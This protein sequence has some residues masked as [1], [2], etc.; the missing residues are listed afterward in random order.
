MDADGS[1]KQHI[2]VVLTIYENFAR[3]LQILLYSCG[4][5]TRLRI[6]EKQSLSREG[7][8]WRKLHYL[9]A[10]TNYSREKIN[11]I[12][13]LFKKFQFTSQSA[14]SFPVSFI[15]DWRVK[16]KYCRERMNI[17]TYCKVYGDIKMC[18]CEVKSVIEDIDEQTYDIEVEGKSEFYCDGYLCHNSAFLILGH[19]EDDEFIHLKDY[20]RNPERRDYGWSSN[21]SIIAK[22]GMDYSRIAEIIVDRGEPGIFWMENARNY[23][24]MCELPDYKDKKVVGTN[25]CVSGDTLIAVADGRI[26]VS[27]KQLAEEGKDVPVYSL[28]KNTGDIEM[29]WG[30]NP[31]ITGAGKKLYRVLFDDGHHIDVTENHKFFTMDKKEKETK[32]LVKGDSI[33]RFEKKFGS[34]Y[35]IVLKNIYNKNYETENRMIGKFFNPELNFSDEKNGCMDTEDLIELHKRI[36]FFKD[37]QDKLTR[38]PTLEEFQEKYSGEYSNDWDEFKQ[39]CEEYNHRV[40]SVKNYLELIQYITLQ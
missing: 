32:E 9:Y 33:P 37:L 6:C 36:M 7:K 25:P 30:R 40:I 16:Q 24:R 4:V 29:K 22:V 8:G 12:P 19:P 17:D 39:L 15:K 28:N 35:I 13:Q 3:E 18:P 34:G 2:Q 38:D 31:R 14:N 5:E 1:V 23:S 27:I 20:N 26:T 21:N 11:A 10:I